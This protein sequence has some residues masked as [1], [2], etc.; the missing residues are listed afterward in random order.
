MKNSIAMSLK[1]VR[2]ALLAMTLIASTHLNCSVVAEENDASPLFALDQET[3]ELSP[4]NLLNMTAG[5]TQF[6]TDHAWKYGYRLQQNALTGHWRL[7]SADDIRVTWGSRKHCTEKLT[8]ILKDENLTG[9]SVG[10]TRKHVVVLLHGLFR[11][12]HSMKSLEQDLAEMP[13]TQV[14]RF[15]YASTRCSIGDHAA[16]LRE[17][18]EGLPPETRFSFVGHSMGNIVVRHLVGDLQQ[19][20]DA[21][22]ILSRCESMVMLGPPNQGAAIARRINST[23]VFESVTGQGCRE[24]GGDWQKFVDRL[25]TPP[26]PFAIVAGDLSENKVQNPLVD[27]AGDFV[28]S[29]EEAQLDGCEAFYTV[30]VLHSFLMSDETAR[31]HAVEFLKTHRSKNENA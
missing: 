30:P 25:A 28:V 7:L 13:D 19:D 1:S 3:M 2:L 20:G 31:K 4:K 8:E 6:W 27:G 18:L 23:G 5:G 15:S 12:R 17:L 11:T 21:G 29:L 24:L 16:A 22:G 14:I 10:L 9:I 26:F